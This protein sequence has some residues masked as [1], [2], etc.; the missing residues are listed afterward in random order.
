MKSSSKSKITL[1]I[2]G[3]LKISHICIDDLSD[4]D[5]LKRNQEFKNQRMNITSFMN[6]T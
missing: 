6:E 3:L 4:D 1:K 2:A 5:V